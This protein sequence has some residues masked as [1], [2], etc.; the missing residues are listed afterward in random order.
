MDKAILAYIIKNKSKCF[1]WF[2]ES[3]ELAAPSAVSADRDIEERCSIYLESVTG[4]I[5]QLENLASLKGGHWML[6]KPR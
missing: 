6:V 2:C 4:R 1:H 5:V 3:C